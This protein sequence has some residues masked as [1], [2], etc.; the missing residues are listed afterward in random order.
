MRSRFTPIPPTTPR[1]P[2]GSCSPPEENC[3]Q[4][5]CCEDRAMSCY[6]KSKYWASCKESCTPGIDPND[7]PKYQTPWTCKLLGGS[8]GGGGRPPPRPPS[9]RR[10]GGSR[11]S[12]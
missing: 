3:Q 11:P 10:R 4:T 1:P 8:G 7:P 5:K 2:A 12:P 9:S 6:E